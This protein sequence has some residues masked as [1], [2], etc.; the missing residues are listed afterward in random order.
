M[1]N[2]LEGCQKALSHVD[3]TRFHFKG[4]DNRNNGG[5][6]ERHMETIILYFSPSELA[7]V[8]GIPISEVFRMIREGELPYKDTEDG[9]K[10][11]ITYYL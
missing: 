10:I 1:Q 6:E 3:G 8:R 7:M 11:P 5:K 9:I 2:K 4:K